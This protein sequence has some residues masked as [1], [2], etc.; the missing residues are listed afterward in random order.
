MRYLL[1][2][3]Q[4]R[5]RKRV[6]FHDTRKFKVF[7]LSFKTVSTM[8]Y[9]ILLKGL[10]NIKIQRT[11]FLFKLLPLA[12]FHIQKKTCGHE[13]KFNEITEHYIMHFTIII[14]L[15]TL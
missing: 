15:S 3:V 5:S 10:K 7:Y 2:A 6:L 12:D 8:N 9:I 4:I 14:Y 13:R 1:Y 11:H